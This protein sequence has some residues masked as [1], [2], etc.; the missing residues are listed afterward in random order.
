MINRSSN[1]VSGPHQKVLAVS[2]PFIPAGYENSTKGF[3]TWVQ[4]V[5]SQVHVHYVPAKKLIA[6]QN[7]FKNV[8]KR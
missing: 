8:P 4:Y 3:N 2:S 1:Q 7:L 5:K 6:Y